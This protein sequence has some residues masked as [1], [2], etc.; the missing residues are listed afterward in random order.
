[1]QAERKMNRVRVW[2]SEQQEKLRFRKIMTAVIDVEM[3]SRTGKPERYYYEFY[4]NGLGKRRVNV[5]SS[6][7]AGE[8][9]AWRFNSF[10]PIAESWKNNQIST[11][12]LKE[13]IDNGVMENNASSVL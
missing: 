7:E 12:R 10:W 6:A 8:Y 5:N 2:L 9:M 1:M 3:S 13:I 4:E 11:E